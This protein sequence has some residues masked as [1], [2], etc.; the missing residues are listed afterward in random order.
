MRILLVE[1]AKA[2]VTLGG[3]DF[4]IFEPLALEY[5]G[6]G[7]SGR[8]EVRLLDQRLDKD[9]R[10]TVEDF[11][12]DVV[13]ISAYT[14]HVGVARR[15]A[16]QVKAWRP[17]ALTVVG[18]HH[19]TVA[20]RDFASPFV[21]L[22][23]VGEG[24]FPFQSIVERLDAGEGF[25]GIPGVALVEGEQLSMGP[26]PNA[27]DLDALPFPDRALTARYRKRYYSEYLKPLASIRTSKGCPY[28]CSFCALWK[29]TE[30]RYL[31]RAPE[32]IVE[33]LAGIQE[34]NVFFAD[35][36]SLLDAARMRTLARLIR[37]AGVRK[38]YFLYAR[39]DTIARNR[40]LLAAWKEIGLTRVFVGFESFRDKDLR[41]IGKGSTLS[42]N[43]A[44]A[45]ILN[46][47][48]IDTHAS[49]IVRPDFDRRDFEAMRRYCRAL[50]L[51]Y[52]GFAVLTPL[53]GTDDYEEARDRLLTRDP[54]LF[55]FIHTVLPTRLPLEAF[56][57]EYLR[58][59][60]GAVS[61]AKSLS[62]LRKFAWRDLPGALVRLR[63]ITRRIRNAPRDYRPG[64]GLESPAA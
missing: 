51:G 54:A 22:V 62:F 47:L 18:G 28:R 6:A 39:T 2:P 8:H 64:P 38:R 21:D 1:P 55:D 50:D 26:P 48:G 59:A 41:R 56:Y 15:L 57:R 27:I 5:V 42:D 30:G 53:P 31:R 10:G 23:V 63:R 13:G 58:L 44:A 3:E 7:V 32:K 33:E 60:T 17:A 12:P 24:V 4:Q 61:P 19:A 25:A 34:E 36:E 14:V 40:D 52:V 43:A 9:V 45:R 20:P 46:D 11:R 49:L 35:D 16:E 29:L 37:E